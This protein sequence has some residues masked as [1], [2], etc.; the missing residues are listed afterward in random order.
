MPDES[1]SATTP[2]N[3]TRA[4]VQE[5]VARDRREGP[6]IRQMIPVPSGEDRVAF[7]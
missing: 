1:R 6:D 3:R 2:R 5:V 7:G 4:E